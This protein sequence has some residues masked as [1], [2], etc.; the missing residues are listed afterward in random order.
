MRA[1]MRSREVSASRSGFCLLL[2]IWACGPGDDAAT[3]AGT[4]ALVIEPD[5]TIGLVEGDAAYLFGDIGA[6]AVDTVGRVYVGDRSGSTIRAYDETGR[7][8]KHIARRGGGPG[9]ISDI[10]A[11]I[12]ATGHSTIYVRDGSRITV[13]APSRSGEVADSVT[14]LWPTP[15]LGNLTPTRSRVGA[16]G[17]HYYYPSGRYGRDQLPR[18]FYHV[19]DNGVVTNDTLEVPPYPGLAARRPAMYRLGRDALLLPGLSHV[20]FAPLPAWDVTPAG[21]LLSSA[22]TRYALIETDVNDDTVRVIEGPGGTLREIP[23]AEAADSARALDARLDSLRVPIDEV[24]GVGEGV[25]ERRLPAELPALIG[26][27]VATNG[28]IWVEQWPPEGQGQSRFYDVFDV[29]GQFTS[30]VVLRAALNRDPP[31]FFGSHFLA[32]VTT[33]SATGVERVVRFSIPD[34][35]K[36]NAL[37]GQVEITEA[38]VPSIVGAVVEYMKSDKVFDDESPFRGRPLIL[39]ASSAETFRNVLHGRIPR[40]VDSTERYVARPEAEVVSCQNAGRRCRILNESLLL[41]IEHI[42]GTTGA[43][44]LRLRVNSRWNEGRSETGLASNTRVLTIARVNGVWGVV[45]AA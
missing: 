33:D 32:G 4:G 28:T 22:A 29:N 2:S 35:L 24:Q 9:E 42:E 16:D 43:G 5:L 39:N 31:A 12:A 3:S 26:I 19:L 41:S 34:Q 27:H 8:I 40:I 44:E 38:E 23:A 45:D 1:A 11:D 15:G 18:F 7:Y 20:P 14:A 37:A 36:S 17:E 10:P 21:T 13:F 25:R 30:S 6:V